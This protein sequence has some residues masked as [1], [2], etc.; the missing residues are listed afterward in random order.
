MTN[1]Q[2]SAQ[3]RQHLLSTADE[4]VVQGQ[5]ASILDQVAVVPQRPKLVAR[6]PWFAGG[7]GSTSSSQLR[8]ALLVAL[9][10]IGLTIAGAIYV[11]A[12]GPRIT[13]DQE[14]VGPTLEPGPEATPDRAGCLPFLTQFDEA[15]T[16]TADT[17]SLSITVSVPAT[18]A[19]PWMGWRDSFGLTS[20][21]CTDRTGPG[22][23]AAS[24]VTEVDARACAVSAA[25]VNTYEEA[26]AAVSTAQGIDVL[27]RTEETLGGYSATLFDL[28]VHDDLNACSNGGLHLVDGVPSFGPGSGI[29]LY[30]VNVDGTTLAVAL[31]G[32]HSWSSDFRATVDE[33]LGSMQIDPS[34]PEESIAP[35]PAFTS[36]GIRNCSPADTVFDAPGTY[37]APAGSLSLSVDVPGTRDDP[38]LG[39]TSRFSLRS[40]KGA[41]TDFGRGGGWLE[42]SEVTRVETEACAGA[43]VAVDTFEEA[44]AAISSAKGINVD[45]RTDVTLAGYTGTR[46]G[47]RL[48]ID[49]NACAEQQIPL[50]NGMTRFDPGARYPLYLI[51]VDGKTLAIALYE[52]DIWRPDVTAQVDEILASLRIDTT[53]SS[54]PVAADCVEF[55]GPSRYTAPAGSMSVMVSVPGSD[56]EPW[57]GS[58]RHFS[59]LRAACADQQGT[60]WIEASEVDLVDMAACERGTVEIH[61]TEEAIAAVGTAQG[62]EVTSQ[63]DAKLGGYS[64]TKFD[65]E[66]P[67]ITSRCADNQIPLVDGVNPFD[68]GL[69]YTLYLID[70]NGKTLA[71]ALYGPANWSA[72]VSDTIEIFLDSMQIEP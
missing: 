53:A 8:W 41:C 2:F 42:A 15:T 3:L 37:T 4:R 34:R 16:Y 61:S 63:T 6:L 22:G 18:P 55:R 64:G 29:G 14:V 36:G 38:W 56:A 65:F 50:L 33:I 45:E 40:L 26:V 13:A 20:G 23:I 69:D 21:A 48:D 35:P 70:V 12:P 39:L 31:H 32:Y 30:L 54:E 58:R 60:G 17:H 1:E 52:T 71:V 19:E 24:E 7:V 27:L 67:E 46:L 72:T 62:I 5:L 57:I 66:I 11:G 44:L 51:D 25:A 59:L 9:A 43:G 28:R 47:L 68:V 49:S 10:L